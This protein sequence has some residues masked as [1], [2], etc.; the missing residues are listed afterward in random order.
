M[1]SQN[2]CA[3]SAPRFPRLQLPKLEVLF[4]DGSSCW[5][6]QTKPD[7]C[8]RGIDIEGLR[9]E[10]DLRQIAPSLDHELAGAAPTDRAGVLFFT[11][12]HQFTTLGA[13]L[14]AAREHA[15]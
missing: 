15:R 14:Q 13:F 7:P 10:V 12:R 1:L 2:S 5:L 11:L 6:H 9:F 3:A 4:R 8:V